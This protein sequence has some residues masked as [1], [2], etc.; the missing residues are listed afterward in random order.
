MW[1]QNKKVDAL[2]NILIFLV[3]INF[4]HFGQFILPII[5]L[6]LFIDSKFKFNVNNSK[7]FILL[8]LFGLTFFIFSF[9]TGFFSV[10]GFCV[11]MAYY[12]GSN[13]KDASE[14]NI[15]KVAYIIA[16]GMAS[17]VLL[18]MGYSYYVKGV[19]IL[20]TQG[21]YDIWMGSKVADTATAVNY[22][23]G[24]GC[25]HYIIFYEKNKLI[26]VLGILIFMI[27]M[28]Y[29]LFLGRRTPLLLFVLVFAVTTLID[30]FKYHRNKKTIKILLIVIGVLIILALFAVYAYYNILDNW[31]RVLVY[32]STL[33]SKFRRE[34]LSSER[35]EVLIDSIKLAPKYLWGGQHI[36]E[37]L[38]ISP[39]DLLLDT[40]DHAGIIPFILLLIYIIYTIKVVISY[41]KNNQLDNSHKILII[42]LMITITVQ[43][44]LEPIM[45][46]SSNFLMIVIVFVSIIEKAQLSER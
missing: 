31:G 14:N 4:F 11:P 34:G 40:Y 17:H 10:M 18:N 32:Y 7:I 12:I 38:G 41:L 16:L 15:K 37:E 19:D 39:H 29:D 43:M 21:H 2:V 36:L 42:S 25:I 9:S 26:K 20:T 28:A 8:C 24:I 5:C 45:T 22:V 44:C 1:S 30:I 33:F 23:F 6:I 46:G 3:A 27:I 13:I 35:L